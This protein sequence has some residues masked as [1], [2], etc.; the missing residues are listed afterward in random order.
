MSNKYCNLPGGEKISET[1]GQINDGF[2]SVETDKDE[3]QSQINN[4]IDSNSAHN[5]ENITFESERPTLIDIDDTKEAIEKIDQRVDELVNNPDPNKDLELVDLR[6]SNIYGVF[7]TA[8]ARL[9][10]TDNL[11]SSQLAEIEKNLNDYHDLVV[12][13]DWSM[14][15]QTAI[16]EALENSVIKIPNNTVIKKPVLV[17]KS[18]LRLIGNRGKEEVNSS[19]IISGE[20]TIDILGAWNTMFENLSFIGDRDNRPE[21]AFLLGRLA[22]G[23]NGS[24]TL[25]T[26]TRFNNCGFYGHYEK[27]AVVIS[28]GEVNKFENC[29]FS[30]GS[31]KGIVCITDNTKNEFSSTFGVI[32]N[33]MI[34][35]TL[36]SFYRCALSFYAVLTS[37]DSLVKIE[38]NNAGTVFDDCYIMSNGNTVGYPDVFS[39]ELQGLSS[40]RCLTARNCVH[41]NFN[42]GG[43]FLKAKSINPEWKPQTTYV[44]GDIVYWNDREYLCDIGGI[45]DIAPPTQD[46]G[47]FADGTVTWKFRVYVEFPF[48]MEG[49][50][51][52]GHSINEKYAID[53]QGVRV[54]NSFM[55]T[56][57]FMTTG[58]EVGR[59]RMGSIIASDIQ[60][61][62]FTDASSEFGQIIYSKLATRQ[63]I[64]NLQNRTPYDMR[65]STVLNGLETYIDPNCSGTFK[66]GRAEFKKSADNQE[67]LKTGSRV[68][69]L[70]PTNITDA[71]MVEGDIAFNNTSKLV[72]YKLNGILNYL[73]PM[74]SGATASRPAVNTVA[75]GYCYYDT[76]LNKP[77]WSNG[78][79]WKDSAGTTV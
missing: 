75:V 67:V 5:A 13:G 14:A 56:N 24:L 15:L 19:F 72:Q 53:L 77:V 57:S 50:K 38:T 32:T 28:G 26:G 4:H 70:L 42:A 33:T 58:N 76:T 1:F 20:G 18:S 48:V 9:D 68:L 40:G 79:A 27:Y 73:Q 37:C 78:T 16:D 11:F 44:K 55:R 8:K 31:N 7:P 3:L 29:D 43:S 39:F 63:L 62:Y 74:K 46:W 54:S 51:I 22:S 41:E 35:S 25:T 60:L 71:N 45:T 30:I 2:A 64:T 23:I 12:D 65:A 10:N 6:N 47:S 66:I 61:P 34:S 52:K 21:R 17:T 36:N 59:I 49:C 69:N